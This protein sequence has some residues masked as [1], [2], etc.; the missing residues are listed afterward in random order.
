MIDVVRVGVTNNF[1]CSCQEFKQVDGFAAKYPDKFF[2]INSNIRTPKLSQIA[3]HPYK[4]VVTVNPELTV[5]PKMVQKLYGLPKD[6]IAFVRVK[7]LPEHPE[8]NVLIKELSRKGYKVVVTLQRFRRKDTLVK[9]TTF[10]HYELSYGFFRLADKALKDVCKLVDSLKNV[11]ICDR[12]GVGCQ[13]CGLCATLT[14]GTAGVMKSLNLS[15]SGICKF[16]CPDCF[17]KIGQ[18]RA[19]GMGGRPILFD[20]VMKN[21]KQAGKTLH[22]KHTKELLA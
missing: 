4:A 6:L 17:A 18:K 19:I 8:I 20:V 1:N 13:G 16:N 9:F 14:M 2:F 15:T 12:K 11:Y 10:E 5:D 22:I 3:N 7:Y 21:G